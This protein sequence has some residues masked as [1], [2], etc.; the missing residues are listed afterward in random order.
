MLGHNGSAIKELGT[1]ARLAIEDFIGQKVFLSLSIKVQKD[2]RNDDNRL[3][4][5]GYGL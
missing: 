5:F 2:W 3:K 1:Q 4:L